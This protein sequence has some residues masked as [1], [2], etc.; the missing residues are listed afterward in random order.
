MTQYKYKRYLLCL[1]PR[2]MMDMKSISDKSTTVLDSIK[3]I[4]YDSQWNIFNEQI[5]KIVSTGP[6]TL[7]NRIY[8]DMVEYLQ[9]NGMPGMHK[10]LEDFESYRQSLKILD[11]LGKWI[12]RKQIKIR[13]HLFRIDDL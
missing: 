3:I 7:T 8:I 6:F 13:C 9:M 2:T 1:T 5:I 11:F 12:D 10:Q 4:I